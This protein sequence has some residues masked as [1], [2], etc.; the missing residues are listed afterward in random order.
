MT[1]SKT[2]K[3]DV[4][5]LKRI[6]TKKYF[7]YNGALGVISKVE[8]AALVTGK[9]AEETTRTGKPKKNKYVVPASL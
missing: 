1:R 5:N 4:N 3:Q 6:K 2:E 8:G 7:R 9:D